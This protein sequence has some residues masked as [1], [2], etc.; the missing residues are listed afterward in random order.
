[1]RTLTAQWS[2]VRF[3]RL[4]VTTHNSDYLFEVEVQLGKIDPGDV[5][6]EIYADPHNS[7]AP[8]RVPMILD[9]S[10]PGSPGAFKYSGVAPADRPADYYTPRVIPRRNDVRIP[11]ELPLI[12][13]QK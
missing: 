8:F 5:Q 10:V 12:V 13:W 6:V 1:M 4:E 11:L 2:R 9:H 7:D 3:G